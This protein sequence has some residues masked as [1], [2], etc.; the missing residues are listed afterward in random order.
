MFDFGFSEVLVAAVIGLIVIGPER[1]PK[2]A[3]TLGHLFGKLQRYVTDLKDDISRQ[4]EVEE[5]NQIKASVEDTAKD[6]EDSMST[7]INFIE[8]EV[9]AVGTLSSEGKSSTDD[10]IDKKDADLKMPAALASVVGG[11][12]PIV[13]ADN[14]GL[15]QKDEDAGSEV[16]SKQK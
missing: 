16:K 8:D 13:E 5:F 14:E 4:A 9:K 2:V 10:E 15:G 11:Q 6:I 7:N 1:L 12:P 3:R